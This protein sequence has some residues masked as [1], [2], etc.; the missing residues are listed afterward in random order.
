MRTVTS[1]RPSPRSRTRAPRS[2][3]PGSERV[4]AARRVGADRGG[5]GGRAGGGVAAQAAW[6]A[7]RELPRARDEERGEREQRDQ[8]GR[9]LPR[10][11]RAPTG[12]WDEASTARR[13]GSTRAG[14]DF[15]AAGVTKVARL[16]REAAAA[17]YSRD[18]R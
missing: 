2:S 14:D 17:Q 9:G 18:V 4:A 7:T 13:H 11:C 8:L 3:P 5:A 12:A 6:P 10:S 15:V 16:R 1:T